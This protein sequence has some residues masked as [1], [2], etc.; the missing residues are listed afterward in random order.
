M[1]FGVFLQNGINCL[2]V[3]TYQN[4]FIP[5]EFFMAISKTEPKRGTPVGPP[6]FA[7]S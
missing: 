2:Q 7:D 6:N 1:Q 3:V 4:I 5:S